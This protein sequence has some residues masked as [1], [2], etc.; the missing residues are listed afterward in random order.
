MSTDGYFKTRQEAYEQQTNRV[1]ILT[2][3]IQL[4]GNHQY[5]INIPRSIIRMLSIHEQDL[6]KI[7]LNNDIISMQ[8][9]NL[10]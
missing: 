1:N 7:Q 5:I 2:R 8:K 3:R 9:V 4:S 10:S 6:M